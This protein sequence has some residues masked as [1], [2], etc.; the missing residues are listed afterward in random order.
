MLNN[1]VETSMGRGSA[2]GTLAPK[3]VIARTD[4]E[5][6]GNNSQ[7]GI[8]VLLGSLRRW[9]WRVLP[10][11]LLAAGLGA[12]VG[13]ILTVPKYSASAYLR[14]N[15]DDRPLI[16]KTAD[17]D[18]TPNF[19]LYRS[20]QQ[21]IMKTPFVLNT[22][23]RKEGVGNLPEFTDSL[24]PIEW[25]QKSIKVEFP[26][27]GEIMRVSL[28]TENRDSGIKIINAVVEAFMDE[29]VLN[30]RNERVQRLDNL[31]RVYSE[32]EQKVRSKRSELKA[33]ATALGTSDTDSLTVAQQNALAQFGVMQTKLSEVQFQLMQAEGELEVA[34]KWEETVQ[35]ELEKA[36]AE[37]PD[38]AVGESP[39]EFVIPPE[40]S[41]MEDEIAR[42]R[43]RLNSLQTDLGYKH[44]SVR[45]LAEE[46]SVS[47]QI[48]K[49]NLE[50]A[51][52]A[53]EKQMK[54]EIGLPARSASGLNSK[55]IAPFE[56]KY[57]ILSLTATIETL[58]NQERLLREKVDA[59]SAET[60]QLGRSSIDVELMRAEIDGLEDVL[61]RVSQE[62]ERTKIEL[63]TESRVKLLSPADTAIPPD[64]KKRYLR[65]G[66]LGVFGLFVP[67]GLAVLWDLSRR[68]VGDVLSVSKALSIESIGSIP[69]ANWDFTHEPTG[70]RDQIKHFRLME[71]VSA[72]ASMLLHRAEHQK[73][74]VFMITSAVSGEGKSS[75]ACLLSQ[76]MS[77]FGKK[78]ALIDFDL[79]RPTVH[80]FFGIAAGPGISEFLAGEKS[81]ADC[82]QETGSNGLEVFVAGQAEI[83]LQRKITDG[84]VAELFDQLRRKYDIVIV[85]SCPVLP[86][87]DSRLISKYTDGV[88]FT[89]LRDYSRFPQAAR[90]VE[91]LKSFGVHLLGA[92]VIGCE[93]EHYGYHGYHYYSKQPARLPSAPESSV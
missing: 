26:D 73:M 36:A 6:S 68:K 78:V 18:S 81:L 63:Q 13:W 23:L 62:V 47:E 31:E 42:S 46:V 1:S 34:R 8:G 25:L 45:R 9:W 83:S 59:L 52:E 32:A 10:L 88:V 66:A 86:V 61:Q 37:N 69:K 11:C 38:S 84:T 58:K 2:N 60:R 67:L 16:F 15:S 7:I 14:V 76:S 12:A 72:V 89:L 48:L 27:N 87:V 92:L 29:V 51:K 17:E 43:S 19:Q 3:I 79:R 65:A 41:Q 74:K 90:A 54:L 93:Q 53:H 50:E 82:V 5:E 64:P 57:D 55:S 71:S 22:A 20:T 44:P 28:E 75:V 35:A 56:S 80:R 70:R 91:I 21:Q 40:L 85:D 77:L 24:S 33:L 4:E 30:E 49:Q 39:A